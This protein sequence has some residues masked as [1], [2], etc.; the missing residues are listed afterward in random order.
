MA[1]SVDSALGGSLF[2]EIGNIFN[3]AK[4]AVGVFGDIRKAQYRYR[5]NPV[6]EGYMQRNQQIMDALAD[7]TSPLSRGMTETKEAQY[8]R[9]FQEGLRR[10]I[11][12]Q[13]MKDR[14][15]IPTRKLSDEEISYLTTRNLPQMRAAAQLQTQQDLM[16][17]LRANQGM[18]DAYQ[19]MTEEMRAQDL[20][21]LT[22]GGRIQD[23]LG[24]LGKLGGTLGALFKQDAAAPALP[25]G[26]T[27]VEG[28]PW[29]Q[30]PAP[31]T[32]P[33]EATPY[34][35]SQLPR[36]ERA[37]PGMSGMWT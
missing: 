3:V 4:E 28:L 2:D 5:P 20:I 33:A 31:R 9:D 11:A 16:S 37:K 22:R 29:L 19:P 35:P 34:Y 12:M 26:A 25:P 10:A 23:V 1:D 13:R 32:A 7:P 18:L 6:L 30:A 14:S 8:G 24:G 36:I 17:L 27:P 21:K 15:G